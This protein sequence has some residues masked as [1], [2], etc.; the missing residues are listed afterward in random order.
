MIPD[1][2][3]MDLTNFVAEGF[4]I[5]GMQLLLTG[6]MLVGYLLP[7]LLLAYYL[8]RSREVASSM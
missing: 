6:I 1:V 5:S 8:I 7:W 2:D 3:R 4:D